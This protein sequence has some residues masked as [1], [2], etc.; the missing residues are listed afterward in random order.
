MG[1]RNTANSRSSLYFT[2]SITATCCE[3][4]DW[5]APGIKEIA[6]IH[7]KSSWRTGQEGHQPMVGV[8]TG[9]TNSCLHCCKVSMGLLTVW[10]TVLVDSKI[11]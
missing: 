2:I 4:L 11:S 7:R 5:P 6:S 8:G 10:P 3:G 1:A 9:S